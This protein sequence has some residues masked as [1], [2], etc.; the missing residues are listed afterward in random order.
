[1]VCWCGS[2]G[3][4]LAILLVVA[5]IALGA[6]PT[7]QFFPCAALCTEELSSTRRDQATHAAQH[8]PHVRAVHGAYILTT[9]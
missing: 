1:M 7:R 5:V 8:T 9:W 2:G 3:C 6:V 4:V